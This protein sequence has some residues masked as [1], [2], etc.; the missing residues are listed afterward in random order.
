M[1][2]K[3]L[4][5]LYKQYCSAK[6][7]DCKIEN[8]HELS[9]EFTKWIAQ[10]KL[11]S[12]EYFD[13]LVH[14]GVLSCKKVIEV[15]KGRYDSIAQEEIKVVSRHASSLGLENKELILIGGVPLIEE[16]GKLII[17]DTDILLTHNPYFSESLTNW[18]RIHN[19]GEY[20]ISIGMYG[21][22][23]DEDFNE[24]IKLIEQLSSKMSDD[25]RVDYDTDQ[26][27]YFCTLNST[28][29]KKVKELIL[30]K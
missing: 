12:K 28:R 16:S 26:D 8:Y 29:N 24:K 2:N 1:L 5:C 17:P 7:I 21:S 25:H 4:L 10:N 9:F 27:R 19:A 15:D 6:G 18:W 13:Y 14:L 11:L 30:T 22:I 20:D 3:Y 23:Y